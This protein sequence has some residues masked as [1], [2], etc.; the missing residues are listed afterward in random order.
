MSLDLF[1]I[2]PVLRDR[3]E[4]QARK[5]CRQVRPGLPLRVK[6]RAQSGE[7]LFEISVSR[8]R[9]PTGQHVPGTIVD[10]PPED[11]LALA[12]L[13]RNC[14]LVFR[15]ERKMALDRRRILKLGLARADIVELR[16]RISAERV[17]I[18]YAPRRIDSLQRFEQRGLTGF[19]RS[20]QNRF[21]LFDVEVASIANTAVFL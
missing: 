7:I 5:P 21:A 12:E 19:V 1:R 2:R 4:E 14:F 8:G 9:W 17:E 11:V 18:T 20:D 6:V 13:F 16:R 3:G 10:A 15:L